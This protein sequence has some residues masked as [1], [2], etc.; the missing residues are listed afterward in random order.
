[1]TPMVLDTT[2]RRPLLQLLRERPALRSF[3]A[4]RAAAELASQMLN[5]AIGW[6]VY[7]AT[8]DPMSLAYVG[9][10]QFLPTIGTV[11]IAGQAADRFE[12][13]KVVE[14]S[15][16]VET[17]CLATF[18]VWSAVKAP[19]TGPVYLLLVVMS[20]ARAFSAPAMSAML[21]H[22]VNAEEFP[23]A[24]AASSSAFQI[25]TIVGPAVGGVIYAM[26]GSAMFALATALLFFALM[27]SHRLAGGRPGDDDQKTDLADRSLLAG[28]HYI[29]S[30]RLLLAL[31][32]LDLF[33]VLLGGVTALLPIYAK[34][35]LA[36]GT[37]GLGCLRC[38][39]GVGAAVIGL[40][41]AHR[42]IERGAGKLMLACVSGFG[43]AT[44]I[45]AV[46]SNFWLSLTALIAAGGF[47]MVS[48][49]IR[50]TLVQ[51]STPNAMRGRVSAVN[52]VFI[53]ASNELGEFESGVAAALF[54]T[55]PAAVLGGVGTLAVVALWARLFPELRHADRL[56]PA[57]TND[58]GSR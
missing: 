16:F 28:V 29:R 47:D 43:L 30:N 19:A 15:L 22:V 27:Q 42:T 9:L 57:D 3:I 55:V 7:T 14:L 35:V 6:Y 45:F 20:T 37:I 24:V 17:F 32:S 21:P 8:R 18:G 40:L 53:G 25:C 12:R 52:W 13:R 51:V 50:Q 23:R 39:P 1:M 44:I 48:M 49:V 58:P 36:V 54:G 31:I 5:V 33:A 34:D 2:T 11:L 41:L 46:S 10:A 4:I 38:A 26:S 56:I